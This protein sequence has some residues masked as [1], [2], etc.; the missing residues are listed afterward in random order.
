[1][2]RIAD[3]AQ[4][5]E[6]AVL[7][8]EAMQKLVDVAHPQRR[9]RIVVGVGAKAAAEHGLDL[10]ERRR[11]QE[12]RKLPGHARLHVVGMAMHKQ[13]ERQPRQCP[14]VAKV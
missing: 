1:M 4:Q 3:A 12:A 7:K 5:P 9:G 8:T 11:A 6:Q 13:R 2:L 10:T 14:V